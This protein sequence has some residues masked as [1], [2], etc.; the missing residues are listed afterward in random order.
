[1]REGPDRFE[2]G[3]GNGDQ[4][5]VRSGVD[6]LEFFKPNQTTA[7]PTA[8]HRTKKLDLRLIFGRRPPI[9]LSRRRAWYLWWVSGG[10]AHA[11]KPGDLPGYPRVRQRG[12]P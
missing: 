12:R 7:S 4:F 8:E 10:L 9:H 2:R 1:L 11:R 3:L 5:W 6:D